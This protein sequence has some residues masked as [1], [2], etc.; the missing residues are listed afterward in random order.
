[1]NIWM[2][3]GGIF[4]GLL[5]EYLADYYRNIWRSIGGPLEEYLEDN[6]KNIWVFEQHSGGQARLTLPETRSVVACEVHIVNLQ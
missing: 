1:M 6:Y 2:T 4:G 3:I 5:Q